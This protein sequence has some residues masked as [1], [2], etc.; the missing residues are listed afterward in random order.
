LISIAVTKVM[1]IKSN[2]GKKGFILL[3]PPG[4]SS[5]LENL[6]AATQAL[7]WR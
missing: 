1:T 2:P 3:T 4:N 5:P 6:K 7:T